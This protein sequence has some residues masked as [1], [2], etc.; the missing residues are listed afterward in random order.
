MHADRPEQ[1]H[2]IRRNFQYIGDDRVL[3]DLRHFEKPSVCLLP[4]FR[5]AV[6]AID[7]PVGFGFER[8]L[9]LISALGANSREVFPRTARGSLSAVSASFAALRFILKAAFGVE[10]LL[11]ACEHELR[12]TFLTY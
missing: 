3:C 9:R 4:R 2:G 7:R 1:W 5:E 8:N 12:A 10:L 6:A 11:A